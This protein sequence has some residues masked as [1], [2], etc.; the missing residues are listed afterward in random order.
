MGIG[1]EALHELSINLPEM[2]LS[3]ILVSAGVCIG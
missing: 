2:G 3:V 1:Q